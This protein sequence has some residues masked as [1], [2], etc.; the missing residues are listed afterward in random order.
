MLLVG[1]ISGANIATIWKN[2]TPTQ[3]TDGTRNASAYA[4]FVN[5]SDVYVSGYEENLSGEVRIATI[6]K[7]GKP[8]NLS[9]GI[10]PSF[11]TGIFVT[12]Y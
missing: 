11:A 4:V 5:G 7:N 9:S 8:T 2:G 10:K 6:W 1:K 3:L 12:S